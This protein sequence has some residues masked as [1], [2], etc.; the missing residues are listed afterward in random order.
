MKT[1]IFYKIIINENKTYVLKTAFLLLIVVICYKYFTG[2]PITLEN[3]YQYMAGEKLMSTNLATIMFKL[4]SVS[5]IFLT[6]GKITEKT[7]SDITIYL[8]SRVDNYKKF[9]IQ[10]TLIIISI[11]IFLLLINHLIY[12]F[13]CGISI[14]DINIIVSYF[15]IDCIGLSCMIL[16]YIL[17]NN[18]LLIENSILIVLVLYILNTVLSFPIPFA[19]STI[20][21]ITLYE[22][23][24][25]MHYLLG[26]IASFVII[27]LIYYMALKRRKFRIC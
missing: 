6:V 13:I 26:L 3:S 1:R 16:L 21:L 19:T 18:V 10:L 11:G 4:A 27:I 22:S 23:G 7:V 17:F 14:V 15:I 24:Q 20:Q 9:M 12:Y 5:I 8:L 2:L 25:I